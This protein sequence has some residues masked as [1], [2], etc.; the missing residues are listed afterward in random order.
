MTLRELRYLI[1]LADHGHFGRAAEACHVS[2]PTLST[3]LKK[4][5]DYLGVML[6][7]RTNKALHVTPVGQEIVAKARKVITEADA[8]IRTARQKKGPLSGPL[9][10][11]IIPTLSPYLLPW[12]LP[13]IKRAY[14]DLQ[15]VVHED[16]TDYLVERL[17]SHKLDASLLALPTADPDL[18]TAAL[19]D[20]PFFFAAP[21]GHPLTICKT[22]EES[23]LKKQ[24]LLLLADG[25]CLR[26]QAL[27][28]CGLAEGANSGEV[29]FRAT[30]LET[31]RGM[32]AAGMG[33]TLLP[34]LAAVDAAAHAIEIRPLAVRASRRIG[35]VW[36]RSYPKVGELTLL[37]QVIRENLPVSVTA[38]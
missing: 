24:H 28:V 26:D 37:R 2:Q 36:R 33:C 1:A 13:A 18:E 20:E 31:I 14:P 3:Q 8:I 34:A 35:L 4:L 12:L 22:I 21:K 11:G 19:F 17:K 38:A 5:E 15:L 16:L 32:V 25:H 29:D 7:E 30:S 6:F 23:E 9:N 27:A 10:V